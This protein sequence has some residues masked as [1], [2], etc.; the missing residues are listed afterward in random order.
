[1]VQVWES[2]MTHNYTA[3]LTQF[4]HVLLSFCSID[5]I[6]LVFV[7]V[8][9]IFLFMIHMRRNGRKREKNEEN[10]LFA[11]K[12]TTRAFTMQVGMSGPCPKSRRT[13]SF[14]F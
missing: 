6:M 4:V 2:L 1:M 11:L 10:E 9:S 5:I 8:S 14:L 7:Y 3:Q 12:A 13:R